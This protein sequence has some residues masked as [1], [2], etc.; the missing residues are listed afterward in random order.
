L[1]KIK[2]MSKQKLFVRVEPEHHSRVKVFV[3]WQRKDWIVKIK[4]LPNRAWNK[5]QQYWSVPRT[6]ATLHQ[7][8]AF[9]GNSLQISRTIH[10]TNDSK[11]SLNSK[12]KMN[13][14]AFKKTISKPNF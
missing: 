7:L 3:P 9:F 6:E 1:L 14:E 5:K 8:K 11:E 2:I 13:R 12:E 10:F 4:S